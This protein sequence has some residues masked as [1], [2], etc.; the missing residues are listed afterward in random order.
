VWGPVRKGAAEL[1]GIDAGVLEEFSRRRHEMR[2]AAERD[3]GLSLDTKGRSEKAAIATRER[4]QY[5]VETHTWREEVQA[6]ASEHGL[7]RRRVAAPIDAGRR[8]VER[9]RVERES[10]RRLREVDD[11]LA[12][13]TGLTEKDNTFDERAVLRAHAQAAGQGATISVLR[14]RAARFAGR[15]DVL[16]TQRGEMTTAGLVGLERG[17]IAVAQG[18]AG[19]GA[20]RVDEPTL[21]RALA[22]CEREMTGEQRAA[23]HSTVTSGH[24]VQVV[25]A[26]AGT[27]KTVTAGVLAYVYRRAGY[28]V[29]GVAPTGRAVRELVDEA[30]VPVADAGLRGAEDPKRD[31]A[32]QWVRG[33]ARRGG[34]GGHPRDRGPAAGGG[35]RQ[36]EG[37]GDR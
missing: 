26:L 17:L 20:G 24:G 33:G 28:E 8:R 1:T 4:K 11:A 7:D 9:G 31:R 16:A 14:A 35:A 25:E 30:R 5:G 19:D 22:A 12:G 6:R 37:G 21:E 2:R 18:R 29:L 27:G 34:D 10:P 23:V 3:G 32:A 15:G 36:S 13:A